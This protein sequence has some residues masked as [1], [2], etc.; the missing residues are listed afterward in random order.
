MFD[1]NVVEGKLYDDVDV[2]DDVVDVVD[3]VVDNNV[4]DDDTNNDDDIF[5]IIYKNLDS[6]FSHKK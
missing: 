2:V 3:V 1:D 5:E 6:N 4:D